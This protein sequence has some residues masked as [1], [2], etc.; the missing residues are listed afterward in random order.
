MRIDP[1][2][3]SRTWAVAT[4]E[5]RGEKP[6]CRCRNHSQ[7]HEQMMDRDRRVG[8]FES[9]GSKWTSHRLD[10]RWPIHV[11]AAIEKIAISPFSM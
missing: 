9:E 10:T 6:R 7:T 3:V 1:E 2:N 5:G 8:L 4:R 11:A